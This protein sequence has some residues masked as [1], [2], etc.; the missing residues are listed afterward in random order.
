[1]I[2]YC[3]DKNMKHIAEGMIPEYKVTG[4]P[5][6]VNWHQIEVACKYLIDNS[7]ISEC[8]Q[9]IGL[10]RGG[11]IPATIISNTLQ[12]PMTPVSYSSKMGEGEFKGYNNHIPSL[13]LTDEA[14]V[15]IIDDISDSGNT[16]NEVVD[17]YIKLG[18][19][20]YSMVIHYKESSIHTPDFY[21]TKIPANSG[22]IIYPWER[23]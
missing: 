1:M 19:S 9:I 14:T 7:N 2:G 17:L 13:N 3:A 11:L 18:Y 20:V 16:M 6:H 15:Y 21:W 4:G 23:L 5:T 8:E 10:T 22:W 12:I